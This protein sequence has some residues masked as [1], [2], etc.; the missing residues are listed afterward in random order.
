[1]SGE[2]D[3]LKTKIRGVALKQNRLEHVNW[4]IMIFQRYMFGSNIYRKIRNK[5][6]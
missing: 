5:Y 2:L 3:K 4:I 6:T 1:M